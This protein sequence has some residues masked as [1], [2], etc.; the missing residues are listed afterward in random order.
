MATSPS[1]LL[2]ERALPNDE[3]ILIREVSPLRQPSRKRVQFAAFCSTV[4]KSSW[5]LASQGDSNLLPTRASS[6]RGSG[7]AGDGQVQ[8]PNSQ[9]V[10]PL[11]CICPG[12]LVPPAGRD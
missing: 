3:S 10:R 5:P 8:K 1:R 9:G 4:G 2:G 6:L 12:T 7:Q 11:E